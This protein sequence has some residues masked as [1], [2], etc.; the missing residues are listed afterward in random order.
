M[1]VRI[2]HLA[3]AFLCGACMFYTWVLW[4]PPTAQRHAPSGVRFIGDS[5]LPKSVNVSV[6]SS[7]TVLCDRLNIF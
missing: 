2:H 1:R 5:K 3:R 7:L 6:N 4:F